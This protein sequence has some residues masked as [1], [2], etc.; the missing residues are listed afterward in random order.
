MKPA[1]TLNAVQLGRWLRVVDRHV[2][3]AHTINPFGTLEAETMRGPLIVWATRPGEGED[4]PELGP[5]RQTPLEVRAQAVNL[6]AHFLAFQRAAQGKVR[7]SVRWKTGRNMRRKMFT[8]CRL[9]YIYHYAGLSFT[10]QKL[11]L[12]KIYNHALRYRWVEEDELSKGFRKGKDRVVYHLSYDYGLLHLDPERVLGIIEGVVDKARRGELNIILPSYS[13]Y[14]M[15]GTRPERKL[16]LLEILRFCF[17]DLTAFQK[18][19]QTLK[20][21]SL[22]LTLALRAL[23]AAAYRVHLSRRVRPVS[24][25]TRAPRPLYARPRPPTAPLAPPVI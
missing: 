23:E 8:S 17:Y 3:K 25:R 7:H 4:L 20:A 15:P 18:V 11:E 9:D 14:N 5:P 19:I 24:R 1:P 2:W 6:R 22:P 13:R 21:N 12:D 16:S 10:E